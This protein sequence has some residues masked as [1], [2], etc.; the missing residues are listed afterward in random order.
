MVTLEDIKS[1]RQNIAQFVHRTPLLSSTLLS[2]LAGKELYFKAECFQKTGSFKAR[3]AANKLTSLVGQNIAGV[4]GVSSGNHGQATAY[5]AGKLGIPAVIMVPEGAPEAKINAARSY[6]AE[7]IAGGDFSNP[8][9]VTIKALNLAQERNLAPIHPFDDPLVIAGQGTI[10]LEILED[11]PDV[12]VAIVPVGGGGILS[13]IA[14]ALKLSKPSVKVFG[15]G[16]KD[17]CG[18]YPS[19]REKKL[20]TVHDM[21]QTIADGIRSASAGTLTLQHTLEYVDDVVTVGDDEIIDAMRLLWTR[22]KLVVEPAGT[23]SFA[24][25][26]SV[27]VAIPDNSKVVCILSG[28]NVDFGRI[29]RY[30]AA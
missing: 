18:M 14:T 20:V 5:M 27:K 8:E 7:V 9:E 1:A 12:D 11:L 10:G 30:L 19:F 25:V 6:G 3:G 13:G 28:G 21:P 22:L 17:A 26:N 15:V 2:S 4:L 24:A 23:A 29:L 16:A